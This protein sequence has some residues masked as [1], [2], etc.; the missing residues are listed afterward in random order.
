MFNDPVFGV[1]GYD[2][3]SQAEVK[4][5]FNVP[6]QAKVLLYQQDQDVDIVICCICD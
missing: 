1:S 5:F 2:G 6:V 3:L 4:T